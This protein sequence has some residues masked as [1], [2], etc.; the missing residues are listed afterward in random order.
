MHGMSLVI[1]VFLG[2]L[3]VRMKILSAEV[4]ISMG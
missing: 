2:V 4:L 3:V 1:E